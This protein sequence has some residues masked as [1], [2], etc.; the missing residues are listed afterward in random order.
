MLQ[1]LP[2]IL[3]AAVAGIA[4]TGWLLRGLRRV[5]R[6]MSKT[7]RWLDQVLGEPA[8]DGQPAR[9][10]LMARIEQIERQL[11]DHLEWHAKPDGTP[12]AR[13]PARPNGD[14]TGRARRP[15]EERRP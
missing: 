1:Q 8:K 5:W 9:P 6:L 10:S 11:A 2:I 14:W 4:V 13:T 3:P 7:N 15:N 12:A